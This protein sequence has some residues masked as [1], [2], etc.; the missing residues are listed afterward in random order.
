MRTGPIWLLNLLLAAIA[1][2]LLL[3]PA[4]LPESGIRIAE[5]ALETDPRSLTLPPPDAYAVIAERPLFD[6]DRRAPAPPSPPA[7]AAAPEKTP[8]EAAPSPP[9][10][11]LHGVI[12]DGGEWIIL[13]QPNAQAAVRRIRVGENLENWRVIDVHPQQV[14]LEQRGVHHSLHLRPEP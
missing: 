13:Y 8:P 1:A 7:E 12:G 10:G 2:V 9:A 11:R 3:Q 5:Q 6:P 4:D 14:L